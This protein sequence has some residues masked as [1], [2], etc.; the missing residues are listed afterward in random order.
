M[1][2]KPKTELTEKPKE[3]YKW[4]P[5]IVV[6]NRRG[7]P[8]K[9]EEWMCEAVI[10]VAQD[11]GFHTAMMVACGI[12]KDTFY[13]YKN[14]IPE[15]KEAVEY[16][17]LIS[18]AIQEATLVAGMRGEI[19]NYNFSANAMILNNKYRALYKT[20][21]GDNTEI[22][23]NNN[24]INLT[25]TEIDDRLNRVIETLKKSGT[26]VKSLVNL[27]ESE[28]IEHTDDE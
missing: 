24:T 26:D 14:D 20:G 9:Y 15:F 10:Q 21:T 18:L 27:S 2:K 7:A 4:V 8:T 5:P 25:K 3:P 16:A 17:D 23:I 1:P 13:K 11:G 28:V 22:N 6:K 12:D 19:R